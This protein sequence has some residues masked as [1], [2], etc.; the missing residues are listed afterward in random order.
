M[1]PIGTTNLLILRLLRP[2][3]IEAKRLRP[4]RKQADAWLGAL[5]PGAQVS[6]QLVSQI[7]QLGLQFR[8]SEIGA[9]RRPANV[10]YGL[11]YAFPIVAAYS[12][13]LKDS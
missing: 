11:S 3:A 1:G 2:G 10:G 9:W 4:F 8:L 5:F 7:S 13:R 12:L 6:V